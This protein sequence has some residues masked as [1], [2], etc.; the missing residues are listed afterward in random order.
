MDKLENATPEELIRLAIAAMKKAQDM[1]INAH[2]TAISI[3]GI[4]TD[5]KVYPAEELDQY[6]SGMEIA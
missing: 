4:D 2:N 6:F 3:V 1:E 5:F